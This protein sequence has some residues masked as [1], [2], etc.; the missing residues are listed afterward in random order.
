[1][2]SGGPMLMSTLEPGG[3]I[4]EVLEGRGGASGR[5]SAGVVSKLMSKL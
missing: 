1:M 4:K 3:G 5:D 2:Q